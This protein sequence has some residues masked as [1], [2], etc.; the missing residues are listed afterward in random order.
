MKSRKAFT[1]I[2]LLVVLAVMGLMMGVIGFSLLSGGGAELGSSQ[3]NLLGILQKAR[4]KAAATGLTTRVIINAQTD[5]EEKFH[6]YLEVIIQ[7]PNATN[8]WMVE[9]EGIT[10]DEGIYFVPEDSTASV[11]PDGWRSDAYSQWSQDSSQEFFLKD[12]FRGLREEGQGTE[13]K[14]IEFDSSGNLVCPATGS[15]SIS[16]IPK[17][18]L[19]KGAPNPVDPSVPLRFDDPNAVGGILLQRFGGFAVLE[20]S[21]FVEQ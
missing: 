11:Q 5:D 16:T 2:E 13:F 10:L 18:V 14:F 6:R 9:N 19:A 15:N 20:I 4:T 8:S 17:I 1:L 7:D 3:R 12:A 21:D